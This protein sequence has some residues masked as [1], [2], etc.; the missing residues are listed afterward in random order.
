MNFEI[1]VVSTSL[2]TITNDLDG[3]GH[4]SWI[5]TGYLFTYTGACSAKS[6]I[7]GCH[8]KTVGGFIVIIARISDVLGRK[9]MLLSSL[10][11]FTI[12]SGACGAAQ[13][14]TQLY[15]AFS[16]C[17]LGVCLGLI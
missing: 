7:P 15:V 12:F 14:I 17:F 8:A 3:F 4:S 11:V 5:V 9:S 10:L 6:V 1:T 16:E 2:V 13:T